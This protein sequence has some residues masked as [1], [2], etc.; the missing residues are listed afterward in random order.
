MAACCPIDVVYHAAKADLI[1]GLCPQFSY[2]NHLI[3]RRASRSRLCPTLPM[4]FRDR[5]C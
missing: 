2:I 5:G 3:V 1:A 4:T